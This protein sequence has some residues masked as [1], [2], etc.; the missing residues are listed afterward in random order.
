[1]VIEIDQD[2]L[3]FDESYEEAKKI[4]ETYFG[5]NMDKFIK[6]FEEGN[7]TIPTETIPLQL[8]EARA[9]LHL[10]KQHH[11]KQPLLKEEDLH[12]ISQLKQKIDKV[13]Q[14]FKQRLELLDTNG[15][16]VKLTSRSAKD[17]TPTHERTMK[18]YSELIEHDTNEIGTMKSEENADE[19]IREFKRNDHLCALYFA[20]LQCMRVF[21]AK[22]ALDLL[23]QSSRI[24]YDL[25]LDLTF[26]E[27]FSLG[28]IVRPWDVEMRLSSEFRGIIFQNELKALSQYFTQCY[29]EPVVREQSKIEQACRKFFQEVAKPILSKE[30]PEMENYIID[31]SVSK[32]G[33]Y[34]KLLEMNPY[35]T[36]TGVGL[37]DW[38]TDRETIFENPNPNSFEFRVLKEPII[39]SQ[40]LNKNK[41]VK[42]WEEILKSVEK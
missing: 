15:F 7:Y 26:E 22:E 33:N 14:E 23:S 9:L 40:L 30:L 5:V 32:D 6:F 20:S 8:S 10:C 2:K 3:E 28:I 34:V 36:T 37:F 12:S 1:M 35:L 18:I 21:N 39:S 19:K 27:D 24:E 31:F 42:E 13:M 25:S 4:K 17:I 11:K 29:L 16:I 38:D 41:L